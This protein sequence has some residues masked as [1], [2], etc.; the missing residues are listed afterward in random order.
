MG[1]TALKT[2]IAT[3][4][5]PYDN[6]YIN[7]NFS[8]T[9]ITPVQGKENIYKSYM[10]KM[11]YTITPDGTIIYKNFGVTSVTADFEHTTRLLEVAN[12]FD[13]PVNLIDP[14]DYINSIGLNPFDIIGNAPLCGLIISLII[15]GLF[16]PASQT[17]ELA[18]MQDLAQQAIQNLVLLLKTIYPKLTGQVATLEDLSKCFID[19]EYVEYLCEEWKKDEEFATE[20]ALQISYFEQNFYKGSTG[21]DN[22]KRYLQLSSS[23]LDLVLKSPAVKSIICNRS[24]NMNFEKML[25]N[26]E[27]TLVCTRPFEI[28]GS[29]SKTFGLFFLML[30]MCSVEV[31]RGS[32]KSRIPHFLY[33]DEFDRYAKDALGDMITIYNKFKVGLVLSFQNLNSICG[34]ISGSFMQTL[35]SNS[36]TKISFG[37]HTPEE[38]DW[39]VQEFGKRREWSVANN[40][41]QEK[42]KGEYS[43]NLGAV[44]WGWEDTMKHGKLQGLAF[45]TMIYKTKDKKGKNVVNFGKVDF[46][47]SKYKEP[48][49]IKKYKFNK[50]NQSDIRETNNADSKGKKKFN[51]K[52]VSFDSN[53][54][55]GE[56]NPIQTDTTDSSYFFNNED[57]ISFNLNGDKK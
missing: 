4:N 55:T 10:K 56:V 20:Y 21:Y 47:E 19:F 24:N 43:S 11:I 5:C 53:D 7:K 46:L 13:I 22:M 25:N 23:Q 40:Y 41:D 9:M 31:M 44:K 38:Y 8:L 17:A 36:P 28:G 14:V 32:E 1:Y 15:R 29:Q 51:Y 49:S 35:L 42:N 12:N 16:D 26:G 33:V 39:W 2:G 45:K 18:Y 57:A 50:Y 34:G 3:L 30:M 27:V 54:D 48:K 37:N 6:D 52:N